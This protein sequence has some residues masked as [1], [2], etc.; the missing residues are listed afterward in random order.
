[1]SRFKVKPWLDHEIRRGRRAQGSELTTGDI[2]RT[3]ASGFG[4]VLPIDVG[5]R[6][7]LRSYGLTMENNEQRDTR[8]GV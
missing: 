1:M 5:K 8:K 7:W 3:L 4:R 6:I 2:G